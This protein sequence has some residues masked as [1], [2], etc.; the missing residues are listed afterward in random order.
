MFSEYRKK[1]RLEQLNQKREGI[2]VSLAKGELDVNEERDV[3]RE[4]A[5]LDHEIRKLSN[6]NYKKQSDRIDALNKERHTDKP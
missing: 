5:K 6:D 1:K 2:L 3:K 4:W